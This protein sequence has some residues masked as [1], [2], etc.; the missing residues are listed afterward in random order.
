MFSGGNDAE[1]RSYMDSL[2]ATGMYK[3]SDDIM[4]KIKELFWAGSCDEAG[5]SAG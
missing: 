4:A 1:V 5:T 2:A 3:V